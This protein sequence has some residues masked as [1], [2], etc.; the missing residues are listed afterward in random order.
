M[1]DTVQANELH[2]S[3]DLPCPQC[4]HAAHSYLPCSESCACVRSAMPGTPRPIELAA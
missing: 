4:G 2:L 3:H 1:W